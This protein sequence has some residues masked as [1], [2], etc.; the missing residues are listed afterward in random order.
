M[1]DLVE[2]AADVAPAEGP[3]KSPRFQLESFEVTVEISAGGEIRMIGSVSTEIKGGLK[4]IFG[5]R[6][7]PD[8]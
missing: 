5:P 3:R 1:A 6:E 8:G 4:L 2:A 7:K